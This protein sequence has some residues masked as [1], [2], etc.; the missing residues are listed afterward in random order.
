ME[1]YKDSSLTPAERAEDLLSKMSLHEKMAQIRGIFPFGVPGDGTDDWVPGRG[2]GQISALRVQMSETTKEEAIEWIN[3]MQQMV[4]RESP[5][6][7]PAAFHME[8]VNGAYFHGDTNYPTGVSRGATFD[9]ELEEEIAENIAGIELAAG[10]TQILAP[11]LDVARDPRMGRCGESY[12]EDPTLASALGSAYARGIQK[13][14]NGGR[15]AA[16]TAKHFFGFHSSRGG[17]HGGGSSIGERELRESYGKSFQAA[18]SEADLKGI[19]PCYNV[20]DGIP[21]SASRKFLTEILREK[22][23]FTGVTVSDY[24]AVSQVFDVKKVGECYADAGEKCLKAGMDVELPSPLAYDDEL[25]RR[26]HDG[27]LDIK[28]LDTSVKRI[29]EEKFRMGLFENPYGDLSLVKEAIDKEHHSCAAKRAAEESIVLLKNDGVLPVAKESGIRKVA[30]IGPQAVNAR[31]YFGGYTH[32]SMMESSRA[33]RNTLAGV[34]S[35][36][37]SLTEDRLIPGTKV[38]KDDGEHFDSV[39]SWI[40]ADCQT[41]LDALKEER[42]DINFVWAKGYPIAGA[43]EEDFPEAIAAA[44]DA[45]L[46]IMTLGGKYGTGSIATMGEGIDATDINL[47]KCQ[48]TL[49]ERLAVFGK[50]MIGIHFGG[51]PISSD[52]ADR[53]LNAIVEAFCPASYG[54]Q[55]VTGV[56]FGDINPSGKLPVSI[57]YNAGQVPVV[58]SHENGSCW[59]QAMSIGFPDYVDCSHHPRYHFGHG[60]SYTEFEYSSLDISSHSVRP[61][62]E[63]QISLSVTN[64]GKRNGTEIVQLYLSDEHASVVRPVMELAGFARVTL[65]AGETKRLRFIVHP[66]Q[67][68]FLD[69]DMRWKTEKGNFHVL[70]GAASDDIRLEDRFAVSEDAFIDERTRAF[71]SIGQLI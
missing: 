38:Q 20:M 34:G 51:R 64:K 9:P 17:I 55:A 12:G 40:D 6:G 1:R 28:I 45:D 65:N 53:H 39:L 29:L 10:I 52:A 56:L 11:V 16:A 30:V 71:Y 49:I 4:I 22:M 36:N 41:L 13:V 33:A 21:F 31:F 3:S 67:M 18:I 57:A 61:D 26:F 43:S 27:E 47:P 32:L 2:I 35:E 50:P 70:V 24:S 19:M 42:P 8:G 25:E 5:H 69:E 14:T 23:G 60:L 37:G 46:V 66:S 15:K 44:E 54:A 63:V 59:H 58:Y 48:D 7:I 62:E 68:A